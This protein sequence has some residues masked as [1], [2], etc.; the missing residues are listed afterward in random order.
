MEDYEYTVYYGYNPQA[1]NRPS[2][3]VVPPCNI[4][5]PGDEVY[6][7]VYPGQGHSSDMSRQLGNVTGS[8]DVGLEL[9]GNALDVWLP[10]FKAT[11]PQRI[12]IKNGALL[13]TTLNCKRVV[14]TFNPVESFETIVF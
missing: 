12:R 1:L 7:V 6:G 14:K 10:C 2:T 8:V 4:P 13:F 11:D 3:T 5:P 9:F